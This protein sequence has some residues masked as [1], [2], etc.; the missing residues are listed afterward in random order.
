MRNVGF[1][2]PILVMIAAVLLGNMYAHDR[3]KSFLMVDELPMFRL[4]NLSEIPATA[5]KYGIS[6]VVAL[7]DMTQLEE[8]YTGMKARV[9]Q[10]IFGNYFLGRSSLPGGEFVSKLLGMEAVEETSN[11]T[12]ENKVSTT[13]YTRDKVLMTPQEVMSL[14][15]GEF[16]G[17]VVHKSGGF[18]RMNRTFAHQQEKARCGRL[19]KAA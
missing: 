16:V 2:S 6:T 18:F 7:Q 9:I 13:T 4:P 8:K 3:N 19:H 11:T 15:E 5:R 14:Q 10:N 12:S 1:T 17:K